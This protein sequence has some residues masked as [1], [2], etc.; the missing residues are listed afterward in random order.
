MAID[1]SVLSELKSELK[2]DVLSDQYS[3]GMYATDASI[4]QIKPLVVVL[5]KDEEDVRR[6]IK[7]ARKNK[8]K[9]LP[10]GAGTS[11]AGQ[12]VVDGMVLDFSKYMNRIIECNE[13]EK[14][15]RVQPGLVRDVLN[16][17]L[18][19]LGLHFAPDPATS[20]RANVGGMVGNNSSGTKSILY[21]KTVDHILEAKVVLA[22]DTILNLKALSPE[23]FSEIA[24]K[25]NREGELYRN[26]QA[27]ITAHQEDIKE[28]FPKVMRR[29]GGY[30]LDEFVHTDH[31]N[32]AKL[33]TGSEGTLATTLELKL[34]LVPLPKFKSVVVVHF[35]EL[36]D[37]V[38]SVTPMLEFNPSAIEILDRRVLNLSKENL[39]T[40]QHCHFIEGNPAAILLV[41]FYADSLE[42]VIERPESMIRKLI[43]LGLG[44]AFPLFPEGKAYEDVWI[45]RKKG[46]GLMLGIKGDKKPLPFIEDAA[47][48]IHVLPEYIDRVLKICEK[49]HTEVS[50]YAHASVG[51]IHVRPILDLRHNEDIENLKKIADETFEL[52]LEYGGSWSGE[53][54]D[55]LVRSAYNE[56]FFGLNLYKALKEVKLLFDPENLMNPGKIVDAL[57]I[58]NNLRYGVGYVDES[59]E[60]Q[61]KYKAENSFRESVHMCTGVG[62]CRKLIGGTMCPS[63]KATRD[64]EHSTR[65]RANALRL[66]MSGQLDSDGL[67]SERLRE[68]MDL[69]L[70][71]K[72]CKS[73]CPSNVDMAKMKSEVSQL[74]YEKHGTTM[75]DRLIRDSSKMASKFSGSFA[76][77]I[78]S[79]QK[80]VLFRLILQKA[81]GF[82]KRRTLP[83]YASQ[84]FFKW[85]KKNGK[86][87]LN[88]PKKVVLFADT[89]LNYHE[90][91]IGISA[92]ELLN[93]CGYEVILAHVGCC[94]RPKIS[95]GFLKEAKSEGTKTA[96]NLKKYF[97]QGFKVVVCEPSCA[98]ALN[99]DL[100][101]LIDDQDLAA[102]LKEKVMM[103]DVFLDKE[104]E[105][106][107]IEMDFMALFDESLVHSH[108][109]QKALYGTNFSKNIFAKT[110]TLIKEIPSGCC[111]MA[112]SFGYEKEHYDISK[113]IG[114]EIL[115]PTI[116]KE[117]KHTSVIANGFSCRHQIAHFTEN[118]PKHWVEVVRA[119]P[120]KNNHS[121]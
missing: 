36:L 11:L 113:K 84:P 15:V 28:R 104:I 81:V 116:N 118:K 16:E 69:C 30:N 117:N 67:G 20:S 109:H 60:T 110:N 79:I 45:V 55:G 13:A 34:N 40:K 102:A 46:L 42:D 6:A 22:D 38:S 2:G 39:T 18:A 119:I 12:T 62:E 26:F 41:E 23:Q 89:Y 105:A 50:M 114:N 4:Y 47:I 106:G 63:F 8:I 53:H 82:D 72:A 1:F 56:R 51:V 87:Q 14:W 44:Y 52:V 71:C 32:L 35:D 74:Y 7:I 65:G 49:H 99:D 83:A 59:A 9:L 25:S 85:F 10:R 121:T 76:W 93:S 94:Q 111:G 66:A 107:N 88:S 97:D 29:V 3:L 24:S 86:H 64:E 57:S 120:K 101:D 98:S 48:P 77:I 37:A 19:P 115:F 33:I 80:S 103:I 43:A 100:P 54:G 68:A 27:L 17:Y 61:F 31:W 90:P 70:S 73:E 95:H 91:H 108:C 96:V 92:V 5:P 112:G 58:E 78:N 75:R 21:G